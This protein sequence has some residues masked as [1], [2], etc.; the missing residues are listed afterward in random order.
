MAEV[1]HERVAHAEAHGYGHGDK[2]GFFTRW[3]MSTNHKDIGTLYI[4]FAIQAGIIGALFS[5]LIR[6]EPVRSGPIRAPA[7]KRVWQ[8]AQVRANTFRPL[9]RSAFLSASGA[10]MPR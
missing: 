2:P 5:G 8:A 7:P 3:F 4:I 9:T 10:A 1:T 6:W